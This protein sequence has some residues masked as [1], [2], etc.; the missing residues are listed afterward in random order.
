MN[1]DNLKQNLGALPQ[2]PPG[3]IGPWTPSEGKIYF[4]GA[5]PGAVDLITLRGAALLRAADVVVYAGSLVNPRLL[6]GVKTECVIHNS[7]SMTL[8][9]VAGILCD[10]AARGM[11]VVRLHTGDPS[12]YGAIREQMDILLARD[13]AFEVVPGVSSFAAASAALCAEYT[14]PGVSQSLIVTRAAGRTPV[15][16]AE[17]L[18][19]FAAHRASMALFLSSGMIAQACAE[20][21]EG[22]YNPHTPAAVVYKASWPEQRILR[23]V[24]SDIARKA[25]GAGIDKTALVLIGDFLGDAYERSKLY[26]PSFSHEFRTAIARPDTRPVEF[27]A[28]HSTEPSAT[29]AETAP[30]TV[31]AAFTAEGVKTALEIRSHLGGIVYAPER[32]VPPYRS[33]SVDAHGVDMPHDLR[34][35][36]GSVRAWAAEYFNRAKSLVFVCAAGIAVRAIAP[37]VADKTTDP[38]VVCTDDLGQNVVPLLSGHIGSANDLAKKIAQIIGGR[39]VLTTATDVRGIRAVDSWAMDAGMKIENP[40]RIRDISAAMLDGKSVGVA[41]SEE[42]TAPPWPVTLWL[43]PQNLVLGIGCKRG[44][45]AKKL[46]EAVSNFL[47]DAGVSPLSVALVASIDLKRDEGAILTWC[48]RHNVES[49]FYSADE[50]NAAVGKFS[51]SE[52]VREVTGTDNV[53]ERAAILAAQDRAAKGRA[54]LMRGKTVYNGIALALAKIRGQVHEQDE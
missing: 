19:S 42:M 40:H 32:F 22:G 10:A 31:Y 14:L 54:A 27:S 18:R 52:W 44:I 53:C 38:A 37:C 29:P 28:K 34:A 30:A 4:V 7:A 8:E 41:V 51:S 9:E 23:G 3:A 5:G 36:N 33:E 11:I 26:D 35:M 25:T 20:L 17:S 45:A 47:D 12:L 6:D 46:E 49:R 50:L 2:N 15:P 16:D 1:A 39:A 48:A 43:R 13:I 21:I 24:I